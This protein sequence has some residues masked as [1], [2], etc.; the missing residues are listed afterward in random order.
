MRVKGLHQRPSL[1]FICSPIGPWV[2]GNFHV[3]ANLRWSPEALASWGILLLFKGLIRT[4]AKAPSA[5][6]FKRLQV[7]WIY[8]LLTTLSYP[9]W[10][11]SFTSTS[12]REF[13]LVPL[14]KAQVISCF[15]IT[16]SGKSTFISFW[17]VASSKFCFVACKRFNREHMKTVQ[18]CRHKDL[19]TQFI[20]S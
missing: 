9:C 5:V 10:R 1:F 17:S 8:L 11:Q 14:T 15:T 3:I 12:C 20:K 7:S 2:M 18:Q 6:Q 13:L 4:Q 16:P 19:P